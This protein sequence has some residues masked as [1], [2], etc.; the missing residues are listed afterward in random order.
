MLATDFKNA[1]PEM[2][3]EIMSSRDQAARAATVLPA[4]RALENDSE[5]FVGR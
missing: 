1:V 3:P 4:V 2:V 5:T